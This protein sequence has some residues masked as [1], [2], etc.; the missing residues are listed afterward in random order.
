[1]LNFRATAASHAVIEG[2]GLLLIDSG[3][4]AL[5]STANFTRVLK[6]TITS[7]EPGI[8]RSCK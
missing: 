6:G 8:Y 7:T 5:C 2:N 3:G 4:E 1:M